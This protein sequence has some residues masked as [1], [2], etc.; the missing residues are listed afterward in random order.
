MTT[1]DE[2]IAVLDAIGVHHK[3]HP[4]KTKNAYGVE[5]DGLVCRTCISP[6]GGHAAWPCPTMREVDAVLPL[7]EW[8]DH[9][10]VGCDHGM[11]AHNARGCIDCRCTTPGLQMPART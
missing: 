7:S 3:P 8:S 10:R 5:F 4:I 1:A 11:S 2:Y 9:Y 6:H